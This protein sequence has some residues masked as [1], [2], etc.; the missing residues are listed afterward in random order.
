[1][2]DAGFEIF[3]TKPPEEAK[4]LPFGNDDLSYAREHGL[5]LGI[6][7]VDEYKKRS[8]NRRYLNSLT[9]ES[10]EPYSE[11]LHGKDGENTVSVKLPSG[12]KIEH[13]RDG[14]QA[15]A[16][17]QLYG[18]FERW[19]V[20]QTK[21]E[22]LSSEFMREVFEDPA[23]L[24]A[25]AEWSSCMR[26]HGHKFENPSALRNHFR[27]VNQRDRSGRTESSES[28]LDAAIAEVECVRRTDLVSLGE[29]L[30]RRY[31]ERTYEA[32]RKLVLDYQRISVAA[33]TEAKAAVGEG[34]KS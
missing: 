1:M 11:A 20:V 8:P 26:D 30:K 14:C 3:E 12:W 34:T 7:N 10:R 2:R 29:K 19:F 16:Q 24:E 22:N 27:G 21:V 15:R 5:G 33:L 13:S 18:D 17:A 25:T 4:D 23:Y 32:N 6:V 31:S 28:E 9:P